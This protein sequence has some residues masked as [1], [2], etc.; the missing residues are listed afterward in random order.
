MSIQVFIDGADK[1][2]V[3]Q[4]PRLEHEDNASNSVDTVKFRVNKFGSR[5]FAPAILQEVLL[6]KDSVLIF[7]GDIVRV[8]ETVDGAK[9]IAYD[10]I[11]KD[12]THRFDRYLVQESYQSL[13]VLN[14]IIDIVNRY[15]NKNNNLEVANFQTT[16]IWTGSTADTTHYRNGTQGQKVTSTNAVMQA[17]YRNVFFDLQ[18]T[19]YASTDYIELSVYVDDVTKLS[20]T[21]IKLGD[22]TLTNYFSKTITSSLVTGWNYLRVLKSAF[23]STGSPS[24]NAIYK[25]QLEVTA[26]AGQTVNLTFS[27]W[28]VVK[29]GMFSWTHSTTAIQTVNYIAFKY[30][31]GS[32]C[33]QQLAELFNWNWYI[34]ENKDVHFFAMFDEITTFNLDDTG[35]K[36]A[37]NSLEIRK[38]A[39]QLRNSIYVRGG[40]YL[41]SAITENLSQQADGNNKVFLLGYKYANYSL[42]LAGVAQSVGVANLQQFTGNNGVQQLLKGSSIKVG[43]ASARTKQ[44]QQ[45]ICTAKGRRGGVTL[46]LRVYG[47]PSDNLQ[48]AIYADSGGQPTGSPLS[49]VATQSGGSLTTSFADYTISFTEA[50]PGSLLFAVDYKYH[51]VLSR[52]GANN[53]SNYYEVDVTDPVYDG[54][55]NA[56]DGSSWSTIAQDWYFIEKL[57]F[58][59]L[60]NFTEKTITFSA[61][62]SAAAST[63]WT[64]QPYLPVIIQYKDQVSIDSYGEYQSKIIDKSILTKEGAKQR[65]LAE[66]LQWANQVT[67]IQFTTYQDGLKAGQTINV[68]STIRGISDNYV[69]MR[70]T[71]KA[72]TFN[73]FEYTVEGVTTR[74]FGIID[75]LQRQLKNDDKTTD[76]NSGEIVDKTEAFSGDFSFNTG[77]TPSLYAGHVWSNDPGTTTNHLVWQGADTT[78]IWV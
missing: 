8:E 62:P 28:R 15:A 22:A 23:S 75:W 31:Q 66:I 59:V 76:I 57:D 2:S 16:E 48:I 4:W 11:V 72:R 64:A 36:F 32:K 63:L 5:T 3:V 24:W 70:I 20:A 61:A 18:P 56:Y 27:N 6:Y 58:D 33:I 41:A 37:F 44:S 49:A 50:S 67:E 35:G 73:G 53:A 78:M 26:A 55:A 45:I 14:I 39:D 7:G 19:G 34:D 13:P 1:S 65:A 40:D 9:N 12:Y 43:D 77:Y 30:E 51:I 29:T 21:V 60:F 38:E 69:I 25:I 71:A 54:I 42:T 17:A 52:S 10:V 68:N 46:R 74:T 47:A